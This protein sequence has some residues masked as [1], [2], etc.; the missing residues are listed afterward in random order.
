MIRDRGRTLLSE[1]FSKTADLPRLF[2]IRLVQ[3]CV[4]VAATAELLLI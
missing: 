4:P 1:Y 2:T 3:H